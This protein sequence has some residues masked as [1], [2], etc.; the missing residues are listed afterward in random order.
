VRISLSSLHT[1]ALILDVEGTTTPVAFVYETL[2]PFARAHAAEY[3]ERSRDVP[4]CRAALAQ[5][6]QEREIDAA[7][8]RSVP[9][10]TLP[11]IN[12]LMDR[13]RK[14]P[15]LKALQGLVWH[16]GFRSGELKGQVYPDV[17]P[18][19]HRWRTG[20]RRIHIYSS[21]SVLA[22]RL[23]FGSSNAGDLTRLLD[24]YFDTGVGSKMAVESYTT[25]ASQLRIDAGALLFVSD[26]TAE[27]DAAHTAGLRTALCIRESVH[28]PAVQDHPT[29]CT[30]DEIVD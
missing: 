1:R 6:S 19:L 22:Q 15:G 14:S 30:F 17:A 2:F 25:I 7:A 27:L 9:A 8:D 10:D 12:W 20:G 28:A 11:Y 5:L 18:A 13:D 16:D 21:G 24:G 26:V 3:I 4:E 23:L 29:V